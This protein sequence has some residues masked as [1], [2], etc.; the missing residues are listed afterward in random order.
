M[1]TRDRIELVRKEQEE[2]SNKMLDTY[3]Q[4]GWNILEEKKSDINATRKYGYTMKIEDGTCPDIIGAMT[5]IYAGGICI[6]EGR[7]NTVEDVHFLM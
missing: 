7:L 2:I 3:R 1:T 6:F 4:Y 5:W